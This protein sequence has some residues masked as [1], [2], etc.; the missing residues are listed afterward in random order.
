L[1][2]VLLNKLIV[3]SVD[4][5][6]V[7]NNY[8]NVIIGRKEKVPMDKEKPK[9]AE[10]IFC[11]LCGKNQP[12]DLTS[13]PATQVGDQTLMVDMCPKCAVTIHNFSHIVTDAIKQL[14]DNQSRLV[15]PTGRR[16]S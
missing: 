9:V 14:A 12:D 3:D 6:I 2:I 13:I 1:N 11:P 16:L 5:P 15:D 4:D 10:L 8:V 7:Y